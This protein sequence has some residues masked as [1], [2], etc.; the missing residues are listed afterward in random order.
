MWSLPVTTSRACVGAVRPLE[1]VTQWSRAVRNSFRLPCSDSED[2]DDDVLSVGAVLPLTTAVPLGGARMMDDCQLHADSKD[3]VLSVGAWA[4]MN[5]PGMCCARLDDFDW[6]VPPY[7]PDM[8]LP[9]RDMDVGI[10]DVG[11][12]SVF[13]RMCFC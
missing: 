6:V 13:C 3:D 5:Q 12:K 4:P 1:T 10:M 7:E 8:V 9:G 2:S 11:Q